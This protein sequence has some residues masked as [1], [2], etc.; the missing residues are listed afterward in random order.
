MEFSS[1]LIALKEEGLS[2]E[3]LAITLNVSRQSIFKWE[4]KQSLPELDKVIQLSNISQY[5][6]LFI[7]NDVIIESR[8]WISLHN[9]KL[10]HI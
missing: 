10:K 6:L 3:D 2:Q 1:K 5:Q 9:I 8:R 4:S 7:K